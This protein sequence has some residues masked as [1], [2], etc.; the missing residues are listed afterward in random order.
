[1]KFLQGYPSSS[2]RTICPVLT[3]CRRQPQLRLCSPRPNH[4]HADIKRHKAGC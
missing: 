4:V 2:L 1:M 3:L